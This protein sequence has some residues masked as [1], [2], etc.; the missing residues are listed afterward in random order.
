MVL[1]TC[2]WL[3]VGKKGWPER[4]FSKDL[5]KL[6]WNWAFQKLA[7]RVFKEC[8]ML[9]NHYHSYQTASF[10]SLCDIWKLKIRLGRDYRSVQPVFVKDWA[11]IFRTEHFPKL[12]KIPSALCLLTKELM[13]NIPCGLVYLPLTW[14]GQKGWPERIFSKD[15]LKIILELSISKIG[16]EGV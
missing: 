8:C 4:I 1:F 10:R 11:F 9:C 12:A 14:C 16:P 13:S 7:L 6:F 3:G 5:L 2:L 15:L